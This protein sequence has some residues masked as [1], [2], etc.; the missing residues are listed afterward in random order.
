YGVEIDFV[1]NKNGFLDTTDFERMLTP[2]TRLL[3]VSFVEFV[4]GFKND[5][6]T[7][8]ELC[9]SRGIIFCVDSIQGLG[10]VPLD[11]EDFQID[12]LANGGHKWLMGPAGIGLIYVRDHLF[13]KINPQHIGWLSVKDAWNFFD[14]NLDLLDD[15][16][17]FET[18][19][20]NWLGVYGLQASL[21]LLLEVGIDNIYRHLLQ[22][23]GI[24]VDG[25]RENGLNIVS[26]QDTMHRSGIISF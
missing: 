22:I 15:A 20:E 14:Y 25:L 18:A 11:V 6:K 1:K 4:N 3:S 7:L 2:Q 8:G 13:D 19:T 10:A 26:S 24:L 23:T 9:R 17:R 21:D 5:L 12:Y 16:K